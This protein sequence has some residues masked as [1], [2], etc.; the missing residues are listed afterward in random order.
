[1]TP[2]KRRRGHSEGAIYLRPDGR[3]VAA[4]DLG[5]VNGKRR[6]KYV[7][8]KTRKEVADKLKALHSQQA[9]GLALK[10]NDR[11]TVGQHLAWWLE[12]MVKGKGSPNTYKTYHSLAHQ[13]LIPRLGATRLVALTSQQCQELWNALAGEIGPTT[14][15][16]ARKVLNAALEVAVTFGDL[17]R[18]PVKG[19]SSPPVPKRPA[20]VADR[21]QV[22]QLLASAGALDLLLRVAIETGMRIGELVA[23][24]RS[25]L[26]L[27]SRR[28]TVATRLTFGLKQGEAK[29]ELERGETKGKRARTLRLS[30]ELTARLAAQLA[31]HTHALVFCDDDGAPLKMRTVV[32]RFKTVLKA[33]GL[34][35]MRFHDLRHWAASLALASGVNALA[36]SERLGHSS[37]SVTMDVYAHVMPQAEQDAADTMGKLLE[38][39][40]G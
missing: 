36:V 2:K 19:T 4:V 12:Q 3:W 40:E 25:D 23:L 38:G 6:R 1:M 5:V 7:Y 35:P 24:R 27:T 16:D 26:D 11:K 28:L 32:R 31:T 39:D 8:G 9:Q 21:G 34:P 37:F 13:H 14:A 20:P 17:P 15:H 22:Q 33:A 18:N 30:N 29:A 10:T